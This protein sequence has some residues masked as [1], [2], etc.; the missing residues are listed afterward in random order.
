MLGTFSKKWEFQYG[1][2]I[3]HIAIIVIFVHDGFKLTRNPL[4]TLIKGMLSLLFEIFSAT[5]DLGQ[6]P[7][8]HVHL[9]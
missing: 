4:I 6:L 1:C 5:V 7:H 3:L 9:L 8:N 2:E